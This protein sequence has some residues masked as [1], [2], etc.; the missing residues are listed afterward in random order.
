MLEFAN[1]RGRNKVMFTGYYPALSY[2]RIFAELDDLPLRDETWEPFLQG[3]AAR[4]Y[5]LQDM[6]S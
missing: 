3:N 5:G 1:T 2:D 6:L 4:V